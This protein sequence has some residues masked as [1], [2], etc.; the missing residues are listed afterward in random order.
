MNKRSQIDAY[1]EEELVA[2]IQSADKGAF[3]QLYAQFYK[4][5]TLTAIKYV[6]D[7]NIAEEVVQ[8]VFL[9]LW[10]SPDKLRNASSPKAYLY[11]SVIN[12]SINH[13]NREKNIRQHHQVITDELSDSYIDNIHEEQELKIWIYQEID[14]LPEQCKKVFKMNRFDGLK[15]REI[16]EQ[17]QISERTVE[18]HII[19]ALKILRKRMLI[20]Q[21]KQVESNNIRFRLLPFLLLCSAAEYYF[22]CNP[23]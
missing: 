5:L 16:A 7:I 14:R 1:D 12:T 19:H 8:D 18:N 3:T 20:D 13:L 22:V 23:R 2:V 15:Y 6:K 4:N 9:R 10:E 11:R 21:D 17:L